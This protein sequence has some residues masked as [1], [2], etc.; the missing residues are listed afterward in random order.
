MSNK[1]GTSEQVISLPK[2]CGT[3]MGIGEIF[4]PD[5][6]TGTGSFTIPQANGGNFTRIDS[7]VQGYPYSLFKPEEWNGDL[8]LLVHG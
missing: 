4:F 5:L 7:E 2:D 8:V 6:L 1:S 3:L